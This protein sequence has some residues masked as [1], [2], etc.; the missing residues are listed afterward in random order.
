VRV[1][2]FLN[3]LRGLGLR[4][5]R[6]DLEPIVAE[7]DKTR[8]TLSEDGN[9]IQAAQGHSVAVDLQLAPAEPPLVVVHGTARGGRASR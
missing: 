9:R 7:C 8:F 6:E 4:L 3:G 1:D 2:G 5:T